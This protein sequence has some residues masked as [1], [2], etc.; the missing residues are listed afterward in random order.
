MAAT[1]NLRQLSG[2]AA[3]P[4]PALFGVKQVAPFALVPDRGTVQMLRA[5]GMVAARAPGIVQML[6]AT[7]YVAMHQQGGAVWKLSTAAAMLY[8]VNKATKVAFNATDV[9]YGV[10]AADSTYTATKGLDTVVAVK[11]AAGGAYSGSY[12]VYY[13]RMPI[14]SYFCQYQTTT[15]L[16]SV[17]SSATTIS[18]LLPALNAAY[19]MN[20]VASDIVDGPVAANATKIT[21]TAAANHVLF[22][23]S[24]IQLGT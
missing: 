15:L 24:S 11:A 17:G 18:A 10:P 9:T 20:F 23:A 6:R 19:G 1:F 22:T 2:Y 16:F 4:D 5:Q 7:G 13:R 8:L 12:N 3:V 14:G 21:L